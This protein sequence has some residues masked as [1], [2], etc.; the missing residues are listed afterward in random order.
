MVSARALTA[1]ALTAA[2]GLSVAGCREAELDKTVSIEKGHYSGPRNP[3]L[4]EA[5]LD[6]LRQRQKLQSSSSL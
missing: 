5:T 4:S 1:A 6:E 2:L 3:P